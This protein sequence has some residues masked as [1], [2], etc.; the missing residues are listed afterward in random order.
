MHALVGNPDRTN[1]SCFLGINESTIGFDALLLAR[2]CAMKQVQIKM[3]CRFVGKKSNDQYTF[4]PK[5]K[6]AREESIAFVALSYPCSSEF[7]FDAARNVSEQR[8]EHE[9]ALRTDENF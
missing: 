6:L 3:F 2:H 4:V 9:Q 1:L 7:T 5:P 8:I